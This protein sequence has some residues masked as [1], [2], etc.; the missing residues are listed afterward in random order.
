MHRRIQ[1]AAT[2]QN[3]HKHTQN[4]SHGVDQSRSHTGIDHE[5]ESM[6]GINNKCPLG[7]STVRLSPQTLKYAQPLP[8]WTQPTPTTTAFVRRLNLREPGRELAEKKA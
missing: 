3:I 7:Q 6:I 5:H 4:L 8:L 2:Y 1:S